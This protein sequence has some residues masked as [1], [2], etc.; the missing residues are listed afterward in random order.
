MINFLRQIR[1]ILPR[2]KRPGKGSGA[3]KVN[4][5]AAALPVRYREF[6]GILAA[7]NRILETMAEI[8]T[9]LKAPRPFGM[10]AVRAR[11]TSVLVNVYTMIQALDSLAPG[12]YSPLFDS[13]ARIKEAVNQLMAKGIP[14][15]RRH[16]LILPLDRLDK[17]AADLAGEKMAN[18]G[19]LKNRLN[20]DVPNGFVLTAAAFDHF[21]LANDLQTEIDRRL[22][23]IAP[24]NTPAL[25]QASREIRDLIMAA[26]LPQRLE[27]KL[28]E[29]VG[30]LLQTD[31]DLKGLAFRSSAL[32]EDHP[33]T[34]AAGQYTSLLNVPPFAAARAYKRIIAGKYSLRALNYRLTRGLR[35]QDMPMSA[36][37][38][39]MVDAV[40]SGVV[41]TCNPLDV[42]DDRIFIHSTWGLPKPVVDGS[43]PTDLFILERQPDLKLSS[44]TIATKPTAVFSNPNGSGLI[45]RANIR[46]AS[47]PS[48][49]T[50][51]ILDL[52]RNAL[53]MASHYQAP[54][55]IEWAL[56]RD[57]TLFILQARQ[58]QQTVRPDHGQAPAP[59]NAEVIAT[60]GITAS[61]GRAF[62]RVFHVRSARDLSAFPAGSILVAAAA[63]PRWAPLLSRAA[64]VVTEQGSFA[65]HLANVAREM[66][67]PALF[68][69]KQA[70]QRLPRGTEVTL[71]ADTRTLYKGRLPGPVPKPP[72][73]TALMDGSPVFTI[74][75]GIADLMLPLNLL[76]PDDIGFRPENCRTLHDITR[77]I[78]EK[79]VYEM[80]RPATRKEIEGY[81]ARQLYDRHPMQ[82]WVINLEDGFVP[83][84]FGRY[85]RLD[86]IT[87]PPMLAVWEGMTA[88]DWQGPPPVDPRGLLSVM[89]RATTN[90]ELTVGRRSRYAEKNYFII[91]REFLSLSSRLGFHFASLEA[92]A[93]SRSRENYIS[94][95]FQGGAADL[96]RRL[97][98]VTFIAGILSDYG[99][100]TIIKEDHL[101]ARFT[102]A[103]TRITLGRLKLMGYILI[104]TRQLDMVM[105][106]Q[107]MARAYRKQFKAEMDTLLTRHSKGQAN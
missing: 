41:Y 2:F 23:T 1:S 100:D 10:S 79:S 43:G 56:A 27:K 14:D 68:G 75:K 47:Q 51:T 42:R 104:H 38:L 5:P 95:R 92:C 55:D 83:G 52:A 64:A 101:H 76:D 36:G 61:P 26:P 94:F 29:A 90:T 82:W 81:D 11:A 67:V 35:D 60:G 72:S 49:D 63:L 102:G 8:E 99:F 15:R 86:Q 4:A 46:E 16:Y 62:G 106:N 6:R 93:G 66:G 34:A 12:K 98:R 77:F 48:L 24:D 84:T 58:L 89:F 19:E 20:L 53:A 96:D 39:A 107:G 25:E 71:D 18:L 73:L 17:T 44:Q 103:D 54:L 40:A 30:G 22:Q 65:C 21:I 45:S 87:S 74:L 80:F 105:A 97:G 85:I 50:Q 28:A 31:P 13:F 33:D 59:E 69:L 3:K 88:F 70:V 57:T 37:C 9:M 91:S 78:H 32:G 7:N